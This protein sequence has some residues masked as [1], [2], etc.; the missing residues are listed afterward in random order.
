VVGIKSTDSCEEYFNDLKL[1]TVPAIYI[2]ETILSIKRDIVKKNANFHEYTVILEIEMMD[3]LKYIERHY[4]KVNHLSKEQNLW[5]N[6]LS[7]IRDCVLVEN[8]KKRVKKFLIE[9]CPYTV[10]EFL[11]L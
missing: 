7:I 3:T 1:M 4:M 2:Y 8:F 11:F 10:E 9:L 5:K 6:Y